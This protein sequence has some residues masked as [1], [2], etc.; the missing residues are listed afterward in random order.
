MRR[1]LWRMGLR[2]RKNV[3]SLPGKPDIVFSKAQV[4][5]FCDGDFWHGR[6]WLTL[7]ERLKHRANASYWIQKIG[8][9]RARDEHTTAWWQEVGWQVV[10]LWETDIKKDPSAAAR[11][12]QE[13][14]TSRTSAKEA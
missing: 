13:V 10:R 2:Y 4:V 9:N 1:E 5:V 6:D 12:V 8:S 14:V 11:Q 7:Q 3:E